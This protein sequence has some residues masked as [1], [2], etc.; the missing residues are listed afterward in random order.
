M[1]I[2][3]LLSEQQNKMIECKYSD[4]ILFQYFD[5]IC[6]SLRGEHTFF[7]LQTSEL[8]YHCIYSLDKLK[9][10]QD[11]PEVL[12]E[13]S[14]QWDNILCHVSEKN[15]PITQSDVRFAIHLVA[16][17]VERCL[18]LCNIAKYFYPSQCIATRL[19]EVNEDEHKHLIKRFNRC[20]SFC[21]QEELSQ[22]LHDY[23]N[24]NILLSQDIEQIILALQE[25]KVRTRKPK[26]S[27]YSAR[28]TVSE[29]TPYTINYN[30][31]DDE[32]RNKRLQILHKY[33]LLL[34][35]I[36][37]CDMEDF[38]DLF[39]GQVR[40]CNVTWVGPNQALLYELLQK[41]LKLQPYVQNKKNV[42][43]RSIARGQF[44]I[45]ART[46]SDR[47]QD[48]KK[49]INYCVQIL[50]PRTTLP[51][52]EDLED[53]IENDS[54]DALKVKALKEVYDGFLSKQNGIR[55]RGE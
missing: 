50:N 3:S 45:N 35:W 22:F 33:L 48:Y 11:K 27:K 52:I 10:C 2:L 17:S 53:C 34:G 9:S 19:N 42:S 46:S 15:I 25:T 16:Y 43:A 31:N 21:N 5:S 37:K 4:H 38:L 47:V 26:T 13:C 14:L 12:K 7:S 23:L 24:K 36:E 6:N 30:L 18:L 54:D 32:I 1:K 41:I 29:R 20:L 28:K 44:G 8:F 40:Y 49:Q 51:K 39:S 55:T